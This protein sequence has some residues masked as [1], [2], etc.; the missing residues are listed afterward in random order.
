MCL[1]ASKP[2]KL[3]VLK[4]AMLASAFYSDSL[5]ELYLHVQQQMHFISAQV[6][7]LCA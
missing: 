1:K 2:V 3:L 5:L 4:S 6:L 7:S